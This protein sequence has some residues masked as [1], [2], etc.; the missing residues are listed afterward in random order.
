MTESVAGATRGIVIHINS[1]D[2]AR[3]FGAYQSGANAIKV[4]G[5]DVQVNIVAQGGCV[6][7]ATHSYAGS[8]ELENA[9]ADNSNVHIYLCALA[10]RAREIAKDDLIG[11]IK[12]APTATALCAQRQFEGWA[13]VRP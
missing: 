1:D 6:T 3:L 7:G 13:Y 8:S 5:D 10:V 9:L 2:P 12:L 4:L 11:D